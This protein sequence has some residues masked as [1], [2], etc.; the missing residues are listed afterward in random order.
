MTSDPKTVGK[1]ATRVR[2][3]LASK[4]ATPLWRANWAGLDG[5]R[6]SS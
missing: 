1:A 2:P 4:G 3:E 5:V 6:S